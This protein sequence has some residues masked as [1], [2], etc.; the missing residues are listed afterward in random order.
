MTAMSER[1]LRPAAVV[2]NYAQ[3]QSALERMNL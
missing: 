2:P 3:M 1:L